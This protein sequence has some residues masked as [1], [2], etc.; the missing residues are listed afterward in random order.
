LSRCA[1]VLA[2]RSTAERAPS[3]RRVAPHI[4]VILRSVCAYTRREA[5]GAC[6]QLESS[7]SCGPD[8]FT[9]AG[10]AARYCSDIGRPSGRAGRDI[11][12]RAGLI[13][14]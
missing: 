8:P 1:A 2:F 14:S 3:T 9:A 10:L 6:T 11:S 4:A 7:T 5:S 13:S 12:G